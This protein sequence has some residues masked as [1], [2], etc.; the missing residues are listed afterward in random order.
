M[1]WSMSSILH[2]VVYNSALAFTFCLLRASRPTRSDSLEPSRISH[3]HAQSP[4]HV[5]DPVGSQEYVGAFHSSRWTSHSPVFPLIFV[6][7]L[8][9]TTI[10]GIS[11]SFSVNNCCWL[12]STNAPGGKTVLTEVDLSQMNWSALKMELFNVLPD[13]SNSDSSLGMDIFGNSKSVLIPYI[14]VGC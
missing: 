12:S 1:C 4:M 14:L 6:F 5:Y 10:I 2:Q 7:G 9:L 8:L 13:K 3:G 11:S